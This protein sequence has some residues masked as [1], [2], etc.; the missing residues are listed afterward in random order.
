M[1]ANIFVFSI[2][3]R[4]MSEAALLEELKTFII[5]NKDTL[6]NP[7]HLVAK[8]MEVAAKFPGLPG[9]EKRV[10]VVKVLRTIAAGADGVEGT[11]DD[12]LSPEMMKVV[13]DLLEKDIINDIMDVIMSASKGQFNLQKT[14]V[15]AKETA[16]ACVD[17]FAFL[18]KTKLA[19]K[20]T[21]TV[22]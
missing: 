17:C 11:E 20:P 9:A 4:N 6:K 8:A 12:I 22:I 2:V 13:R 5:A 16:G 19:K 7:F 14:V 3:I 1:Y 15:V 21:P 18:K 10:L